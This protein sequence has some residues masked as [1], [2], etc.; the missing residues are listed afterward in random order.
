VAWYVQNVNS[1][2]TVAG[3]FNNR[4]DPYA[5][6]ITQYK[7]DR[8]S[9]F[10][11]VELETVPLEPVVLLE[12]DIPAILFD[13]QDSGDIILIRLPSGYTAIYTL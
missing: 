7:T 10:S 2:L 3:P 5:W 6:A 8:S 4:E 1:G 9:L 11:V 12:K 13:L